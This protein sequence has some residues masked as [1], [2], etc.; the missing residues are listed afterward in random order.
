MNLDL[1]P[2]EVAGR[3]D[4]L[5][6]VVADHADAIV[7]SDLTSIRWC[8]GFTGSNA[9][10]VVTNDDS[11]LITDG[12]Y[13]VQAPDELAAALSNTIVAIAVQL[14][15][16]AIEAH[17]KGFGYRPGS[18]YE[19]TLGMLRARAVIL[20]KL[21]RE[22]EARAAR[23]G[24]AIQPVPCPITL[25]ELFQRKLGKLQIVQD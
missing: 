5:R 23:E 10:L 6:A 11:T 18:P 15:D 20:E 4:R 22:D 17:R 19:S 9:L 24:A 8:T 16:A 2:L 21:G 14:I 3:L 12:R 7:I 25:Y 13:R 1:P